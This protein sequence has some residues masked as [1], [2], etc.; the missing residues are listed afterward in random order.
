MA[1]ELLLL[2]RGDNA[3]AQ[4]IFEAFA[5]RTG[6]EGQSVTGGV[7]YLLEDGGHRIKIVETLTDIDA[8]WSRHV[9]LRQ[10]RG[11]GR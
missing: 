7:R 6:L 5:E 8:D 3:N 10:P 2:S 1:D 9:E 11:E 4:R